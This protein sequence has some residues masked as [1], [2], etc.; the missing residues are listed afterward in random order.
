MAS[1][2]K[3]SP[4]LWTEYHYRRLR[5]GHERGRITWIYFPP[6][7]GGCATHVR[8]LF[9]TARGSTDATPQ[10]VLTNSDPKIKTSPS[11]HCIA[12]SVTKCK[13]ND[14]DNGAGGGIP[15][16]TPSENTVV[17]SWS[18]YGS[19][20]ATDTPELEA[21]QARPTT[22]PITPGSPVLA[23]SSNPDGSARFPSR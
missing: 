5:S 11:S 22:N 19:R 16:V 9:L 12:R 23:C 14:N 7:K 1:S 18:C 8:S 20:P 10:V 21:T 2:E 6:E 15:I 17:L 13:C 4:H 3:C